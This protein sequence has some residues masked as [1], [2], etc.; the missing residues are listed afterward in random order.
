MGMSETR[1]NLGN[2]PIPTKTLQRKGNAAGIQ[3]PGPVYA[4]SMRVSSPHPEK[5]VP[6][7]EIK[8]NATTA[9]GDV[10]S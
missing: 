10:A 8:R 4:G 5:R 9:P 7:R 3:K 6:L 1:V 2:S